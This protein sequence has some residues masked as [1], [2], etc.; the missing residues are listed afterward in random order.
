MGVSGQFHA[1]ATFAFGTHWTLWP[2][3]GAKP[4][5]HDI[6]PCSEREKFRGQG[7]KWQVRDKKK[8]AVMY[9][10]KE[11]A[12]V[13]CAVALLGPALPSRRGTLLRAQ[14][15]RSAAAPCNSGTRAC[16][17]VFN[18]DCGCVYLLGDLGFGLLHSV[19]SGVYSC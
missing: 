16:W 14:H 15:S 2:Q 7:G 8:Q 19:E 4:Q 1:P 3:H 5:F 10:Y 18:Q 6:H 9:T 13:G 17:S 12:T 11:R